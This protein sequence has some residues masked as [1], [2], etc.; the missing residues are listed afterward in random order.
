MRSIRRHDQLIEYLEETRLFGPRGGARVTLVIGFNA[1]NVYLPQDEA[2]W[3]AVART[4]RED[5]VYHDCIAHPDND[6]GITEFEYYGKTVEEKAK[7]APVPAA[8]ALRRLRLHAIFGCATFNRKS[9]APHTTSKQHWLS[10]PGRCS[11][12]LTR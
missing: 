11:S 1:M 5:L 9:E 4:R 8:S 6:Q 10:A 3:K 2:L 12:S 7:E